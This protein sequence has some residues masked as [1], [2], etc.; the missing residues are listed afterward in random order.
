MHFFPKIAKFHLISG[1]FV[2]DITKKGKHKH[3][4]QKY[5]TLEWLR[6]YNYGEKQ[7]V[8][9]ATISIWFWVHTKVIRPSSVCSSYIK[10]L[11]T[12]L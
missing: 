7:V 2:L 9:M 8:S 1:N 10:K 11:I 6:G 3:P 5:L 12:V 4:V